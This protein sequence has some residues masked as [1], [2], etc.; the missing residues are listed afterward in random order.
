MSADPLITAM[1]VGTSN[2]RTATYYRIVVRSPG[3]HDRSVLR[4]LDE[5]RNFHRKLKREC[6]ESLAAPSLPW[7][8]ST[9][10]VTGNQLARMSFLGTYLSRILSLDMKSPAI[11]EFL[12]LQSL[13]QSAQSKPAMTNSDTETQ[14]SPHAKHVSVSSPPEALCA[15]HLSIPRCSAL[16]KWQT[17]MDKRH[18]AG[19]NAEERTKNDHIW[20]LCKLGQD[21][22]LQAGIRHGPVQH[23]TWMVV[24]TVSSSSTNSL[25]LSSSQGTTSPDGAMKYQSSGSVSMAGFRQALDDTEN[26]FRH[27]DGARGRPC[28][29]PLM[30]LVTDDGVMMRGAAEGEIGSGCSEPSGEKDTLMM[31]LYVDFTWALHAALHYRRVLQMAAGEAHMLAL[32]GAPAH[33]V[34][35]WGEGCEGQL[36]HGTR[37]P[38]PY[39][40]VVSKLDGARTVAVTCG[41]WHS[42]TISVDGVAYAFGEGR[43]GQLGL[44]QLGIRQLVPAEMDRGVAVNNREAQ[45]ARLLLAPYEHRP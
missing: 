15:H 19:W 6:A 20:L 17:W 9:S 42:L 13:E 35:S 25:I 39:P 22:N 14:C 23:E 3:S 26:G 16:R 31:P 10:L 41:A 27:A 8:L 43:D 38:E 2:T 32:C 45:K 18:P 29:P 44:G 21:S 1:I 11:N 24:D 7:L 4:T 5:F 40:R 12:D 34:L 30:M 37:E 28:N 33:E 36:G